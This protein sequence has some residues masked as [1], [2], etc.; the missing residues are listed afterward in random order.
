VLV[1][2]SR[3]CTVMRAIWRAP[4]IT[5]PCNAPRAQAV[6]AAGLLIMPCAL[7]SALCLL[8]KLRFLLLWAMG[9]GYGRWQ[10]CVVQLQ[11]PCPVDV[12]PIGH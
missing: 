5:K 8:C 4:D 10:L 1:V 9:Y 2:A 12:D 11:L 7:C 3:A 6:A